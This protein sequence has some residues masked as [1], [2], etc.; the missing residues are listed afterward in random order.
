MLRTPVFYVLLFLLACGS[1]LG[2]MIISQSSAV[3]QEMTGVTPAAAAIIVS[4][5]SASNT[6][7]RLL[8]GYASDKLGRINVVTAALS[9]ALLGLVLLSV[10]GKSVVLFA[11]GVCLV[12]V[13]F[14]SY[15]GVYPGLTADHFGIRNN[16]LNYGLVMIGNSIGA[17]AGPAIMNGVHSATGTYGTA[18]LIAAALAVFGGVLTILYR[19]IAPRQKSQ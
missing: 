4:L 1:L 10:A 13:C 19:R 12:G 16:T 3:A 9:A 15:L 11:V 18:F 8:S 14:G 6:S 17:I 5:V 7:G 2:M